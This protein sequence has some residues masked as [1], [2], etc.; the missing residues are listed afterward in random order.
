MQI[1][2]DLSSSAG[3]VLSEEMQSGCAPAQQLLG[4]LGSDP[5]AYP[6]NLIIVVGDL[7]DPVRHPFRQ[8]SPRQ[9]SKPDHLARVGDRH[10]PG[11]DRNVAAE[12]P[13]PG[14]EGEVIIGSKKEL[15]DGK[16]GARLRLRR[17]APEHQDRNHS[18]PDAHPGTRPRQCRTRRAR[19]PS[20]LARLRS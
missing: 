5:D 7:V 10:D 19:A 4:Q 14:D 2:V 18:A 13:D 12:R 17:P 6:P 3:P 1:G 20:P 9:L 15:G 8:C 16:T 11:D